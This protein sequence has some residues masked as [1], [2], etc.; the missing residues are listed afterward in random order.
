MCEIEDTVTKHLGDGGEKNEKGK[1]KHM[2]KVKILCKKEKMQHL[3]DLS[4]LKRE[5]LLQK[6]Q[7]NR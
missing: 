6:K 4:R 7:C 3:R 5:N 1:E 2:A